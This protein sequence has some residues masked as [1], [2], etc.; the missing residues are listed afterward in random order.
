MRSATF[1]RIKSSTDG[2]SNAVGSSAATV[3]LEATEAGYTDTE[4]DQLHNH[5]ELIT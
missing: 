4:I 2:S 1:A 5:Q 3:G